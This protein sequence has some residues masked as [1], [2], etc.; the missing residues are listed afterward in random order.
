[1]VGLIN[2][3]RGEGYVQVCV[4]IIILCMI[5]SVLVTFAS[6]V[7]VIRLTQNNSKTVLENFVITNSIEIYKSIKQ[8]S[9]QTISVDAEEYVSDLKRFCTFEEVGDFLY[10]NDASGNTDYFITDPEISIESKKLRLTVSYT[11]YV[12]LYFNGIHITTVSIPTTVKVNL[13]DKF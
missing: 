4:I 6:T 13:D 2:N 7:N 8:G 12:P 10:H 3:K 9:N 11:L 1:M 5:L